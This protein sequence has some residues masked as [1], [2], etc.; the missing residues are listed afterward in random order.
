GF[1]TAEA[2]TSR[3]RRP[4]TC[5]SGA[6]PSLAPFAPC[7]RSVTSNGTVHIR[8]KA[9]VLLRRLLGR[10]LRLYAR[11]V[12]NKSLSRPYISCGGPRRRLDELRQN[13]PDVLGMEKR[14]RGAHG[15]MPRAPVDEPDA[16]G[17]ELPERLRHVGNTVAH[18]MN[19]LAP[20]RAEFPPGGVRAERLQEL[21]VG[22]AGL[23]VRHVQHR[24]AHPLLLVHLPA[25]HGEPEG[26]LVEG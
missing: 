18:M 13:A 8:W 12:T 3:R 26:R 23:A 2:G 4:G 15:P 16:L 5:G 19:G 10:P 7:A 21:D 22:G 24:L 1:R 20:F 11:L 6:A 25:H 9:S 17:L 14:N